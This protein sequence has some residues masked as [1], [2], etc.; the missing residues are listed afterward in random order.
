[1][2]TPVA[3]AVLKLMLDTAENRASRTAGLIFQSSTRSPCEMPKMAAEVAAQ[4]K[5]DKREVIPSQGVQMSRCVVSGG[6]GSS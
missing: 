5:V 3:K 2:A 1:M 4:K 6:T